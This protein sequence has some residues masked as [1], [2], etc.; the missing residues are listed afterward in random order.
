MGS[1]PIGSANK[2]IWLQ[3]FWLSSG[4]FL[5]NLYVTASLQ[6]HKGK[7][8]P[9]LVRVR[10]RQSP[11]T[12]QTKRKT[13]SR[14]TSATIPKLTTRANS[15]LGGGLLISSRIGRFRAVQYSRV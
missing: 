12:N 14:R 9:A 3:F 6:V 8:A 13:T 10:A 5:G 4:G 11:I 7:R 1:N 2:I 15:D